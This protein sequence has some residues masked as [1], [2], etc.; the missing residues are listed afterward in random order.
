MSLTCCYLP[1]YCYE[2]NFI[3]NY[4]FVT[5]TWETL[6]SYYENRFDCCVFSLISKILFMGAFFY[7]SVLINSGIKF[8]LTC[9][10][11]IEISTMNQVISHTA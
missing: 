7:D 8:Y 4:S 10:K 6:D 5:K 9:M 11:W 2:V 3:K 1:K